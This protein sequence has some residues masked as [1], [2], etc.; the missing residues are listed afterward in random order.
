MY[1]LGIVL[2][3]LICLWPIASY[4]QIQP[5]ITL[6]KMY[7][8]NENLTQYWVSEKYDGIRAFWTGQ[9]LL[10]R[11]G[12]RIHAPNEWT[13]HLPSEPLDGEL[14]LGRQT[15]EQ[16]SSIARKKKPNEQDWRK[17]KYMVFDLPEHPGIFVE[18]YYQLKELINS[19][20]H[21]LLKL[22]RQT[23]IHDHETLNQQLEKITQKGA[24]GLMLR[25]ISSYYTAGRTNDL[26]KVKPYM[27]SDAIV[28]GHQQGKGKYTNMLGALIVMDNDGQEFK[29]GT[30]FSDEEREHPPQVGETVTYQYH[31]HTR[32]GVPRFASFLKI[33]RK[34]KQNEQ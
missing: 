19:Q 22:V 18:R 21:P 24:E 14:W 26:L 27:D 32:T 28:I 3:I 25:Q 6:S 7:Q 31:G 20:A 8:A 11:S 4:A 33:K 1:Y 34:Q 2:L 5:P 30:G 16:L 13:K 10:T 9:E 17:V 15:F 12:K 23:P 29:I